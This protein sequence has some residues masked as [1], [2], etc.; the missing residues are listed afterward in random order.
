MVMKM[1]LSKAYNRVSWIYL[2]LILIHLG[3]CHNFVVLV[4]SFITFVSF[5]VFVN[6]ATS[7]FFIP[8][9]GLRQGCPLS[10]LLFLLIVEGLSRLLKEASENGSIK[11]ICIEQDCN[12]THI[13]FVDDVQIFL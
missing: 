10:L 6:G 4:M 13:L 1:D 7:H 9:K 11:G 5:V 3:F 2:R 12:I 8:C